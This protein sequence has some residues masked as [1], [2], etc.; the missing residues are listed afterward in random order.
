ME[1]HLIRV[2]GKEPAVRFAA[3]ELARHLQLATGSPVA[4]ETT[5]ARGAATPQGGALTASVFRVGVCHDLG[6]APPA[7]LGAHEDWIIIRPEAGGYLLTGSNPR[8]AL[9]AV[10]RYLREIGFRWIRPG[11][12]GLVAPAPTTSLPKVAAIDERPSYDFR[13]ICIEGACSFEHVRDLI[14]WMAKQGM[15]GYF[16]QFDHGSF[17]FKHWYLHGDNP[18]W[19]GKPLSDEEAARMAEK[20]AAELAKRGMRFERV[21][22]GWSSVVLG[23]P[24]EGWDQFKGKI[25]PRKREWLALIDGKRD[26]F[27]GTP[28]NTNLCYSNPKVRT[29]LAKAVTAYAAEHPEV[30]L[31]HFWLAD[32]ANN[33]CECENCQQARPSDWY[34]QMLNEIDA[35]LTAAGLG[36]KIVFLI[37]VDLLWPPEQQRINNPDRFV[38]MFAP[39]TRTYSQS[40]AAAADA[41][42]GEGMTPFVRNKLHMPKS[43]RA[44]LEYLQQWQRLFPGRGFDYDYHLIWACYYDLNQYALA[45]VLHQDI[46]S[47]DQI[48]LQGLNSVQNQRMSFPH[49]LLMDVMAHTL[50]NKKL[51]FDAIAR[52]SF[53]DAFGAEGDRVHNFFKEMSRLWQPF[54]EPVFIEG[55]DQK[56]IAQGIRNIKKMHALSEE[57]RAIVEANREQPVEAI[58]WSWRYL[59]R[60]LEFLQVLLPAFEAYLHRSPYVR[61]RFEKAFDFLWETERELHPVLD[62]ATLVKVLKWRIHEAETS[63]GTTLAGQ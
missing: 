27:G 2:S 3:K 31:L 62:A 52:T 6:I 4:T 44:N 59:T 49:N 42:D 21:G 39:I 46:R 29:A 37:Y 61:Q 15:N 41:A 34:V 63:S 14:D 51:S 24:S 7:D 57:L 47:M 1:N 36:T 19:Q 35:H 18:Y 5:K 56:R 60:Y 53:R 33:H 26:L 17:F 28:L 54:F 23:L 22:H 48:G 32:G 55:A 30:D 43:A 38:L 10:Y 58:A 8:S 16:I 13:T 25:P 9:F 45:R 12:R 20:V 50:W 11:A 40:F